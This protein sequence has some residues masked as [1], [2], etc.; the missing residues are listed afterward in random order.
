[1]YILDTQSDP[2]YFILIHGDSKI[3]YSKRAN[4]LDDLIVALKRLGVK[5]LQ[6]LK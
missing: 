5:N 3:R 1:M 6:I 4:T 2:E